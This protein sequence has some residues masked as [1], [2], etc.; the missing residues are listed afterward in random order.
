MSTVS[1]KRCATPCKRFRRARAKARAGV[2][3]A[4][5]SAAETWEDAE[6]A[7]KD[8][9]AASLL[10]AIGLGIVVGYFIRRG[11]E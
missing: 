6:E 8:H 1:S 3:S 9:L 5:D 11:T 2:T 4:R 10:L 7:M